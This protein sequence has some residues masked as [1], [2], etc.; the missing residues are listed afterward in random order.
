MEMQDE[1]DKFRKKFEE[2][3]KNYQE[4]NKKLQ[5]KYLEENKK[6]EELQKNID[7]LQDSL[8][9]GTM[10][11]NMELSE[12]KSKVFKLETEKKTEQD[13]YKELLNNYEKSGENFMN[14]LISLAV[15]PAEPA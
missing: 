10:Q 1:S 14:L 3:L 13:K 9:Q 4:E 6:A 2:Q 7:Y 12:L 8:V 15:S 11:L 5:E